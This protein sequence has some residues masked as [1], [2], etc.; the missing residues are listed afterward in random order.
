[1]IA[2][3]STTNSISFG[4]LFSFDFVPNIFLSIWDVVFVDGQSG[5]RRRRKDDATRFSSWP[6][7]YCDRPL[8]KNRNFLEKIGMASFLG[9]WPTGVKRYFTRFMCLRIFILLAPPFPLDS[10]LPDNSSANLRRVLVD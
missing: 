5:Q 8:E 2:R 3:N 7:A 9:H 6:V 10:C 1:M 4:A